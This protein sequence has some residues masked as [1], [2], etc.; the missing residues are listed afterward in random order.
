M[1]DGSIE[2]SLDNAEVKSHSIISK[3]ATDQN[4]LKIGIKLGY[5]INLGSWSTARI[6][7]FL[8]KNYK[9]GEEDKVYNEIKQWI[10][11]KLDAEIEE[12]KKVRK[13]VL[14]LEEVQ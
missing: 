9:P 8:E 7:I 13:K 5:T 12:I 6:D 3:E 2:V 1:S 14:L 10:Q 4:G 11:K